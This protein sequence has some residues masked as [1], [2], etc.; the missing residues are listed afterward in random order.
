[1]RQ[2]GSDRSRRRHARTEQSIELQTLLADN[3]DLVRGLF[4]TL[5]RSRRPGDQGNLQSTG[6]AVE[7][8]QLAAERTPPGRERSSRLQRVPVFARIAADEMRG[9]RR[10][11]PHGRHDGTVSALFA[12]VGPVALWVILSGELSLADAQRASRDVARAGDIIG[13]LEHAVRDGRLD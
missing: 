6:A 3:T 1:M 13:S 12:A 10:D 2:D 11:H 5:G 4:T 9:A 7:F 8:E